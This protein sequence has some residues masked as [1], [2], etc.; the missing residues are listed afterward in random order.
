M[1]K[2]ASTQ[3]DH[4]FMTLHKLNLSFRSSTRK[5]KTPS[6]CFRT[7]LNDSSN[8][9]N[10]N[11]LKLV[12]PTSNSKLNT[13]NT[14][15]SKKSH[16]YTDSIRELSST[17]LLKKKSDLYADLLKDL[18]I[19]KSSKKKSH[20]YP[21]SIRELS[22]KKIIKKK[23]DL[24]TDSIS[25]HSSKKVIKKKS[26]LSE[27]NNI[28]NTA[29]KHYKNL[30]SKSKNVYNTRIRN[31]INKDKPIIS[32]HIF[33][34]NKNNNNL[35]T[36]TSIDYF[37]E[38]NYNGAKNLKINDKK[39]DKLAKSLYLDNNIKEKEEQK[40]LLSLPI[41]FIKIKNGYFNGMNIIISPDSPKDSKKHKKNK[42][43][44]HTHLNTEPSSLLNK[45]KKIIKFPSSNFN[46]NNKQNVFSNE[47]NSKEVDDNNKNDFKINQNIPMNVNNTFYDYDSKNKINYEDINDNDIDKINNKEHK[48]SD[49]TMDDS[50]FYIDPMD[51]PIYLREKY[52]IKGTSLL[53]PF[54]LKARDE[55]LY[56][57]I[58]YDYQL[59]K[60]IKL[61]KIV[62]NKLNLLYAE[63]EKQ[64]N[65]KMKKYNLKLKKQ[66][67][68]NQHLEGPNP[69]E[70]KLFD[71]DS[72][73][74]FMKKIVDYA[75]PNMVLCKVREE[76]KNR[77][78]RLRNN[79]ALSMP[80]FKKADALKKICEKSLESHLKQSINIDKLE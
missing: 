75:Y 60:K 72:K 56:K 44:N 50:E 45:S 26:N 79:V 25:E 2:N 5:Y 43:F 77:N 35:K 68:K 19:K 23:F 3:K 59:R 55:F 62:N 6:F 31:T 13:D 18:V 40:E 65:E 48:N 1:L 33:E 64:Y 28:Q 69:I 42:Q 7:D 21:D 4:N 73:V 37:H 46:T 8:A 20:L 71:M 38:H 17:K 22:S 66:G 30:I 10:N 74:K 39:I 27:F 41:N 29:Y 51:L 49:F 61:T 34:N 11:C 9:N 76:K 52:N 16:L 36:H 47:N 24:C 67:K 58:F 14:S 54:C 80:P 32:K 53:S 12:F 78:S 57:K 63:N 70:V 15:L